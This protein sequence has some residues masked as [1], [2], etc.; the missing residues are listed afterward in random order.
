MALERIVAH[1]RAEV[2][3][4]KRAAD[5]DALREGLVPSDRSLAAALGR[6]R[7]GF[8]LEC[9]RAS[10]SAGMLRE[11]FDPEA[12]ARAY[13]PLADAV[14]VITD[15][16]FFG[17]SHAFLGR[18]RA[19]V[20]APVLCKDFV[21]DP[22]QVYEARHH[23]AD[24]IL[25]MLSVLDDDEYTACLRACE[26]AS[27]DALTEV[28]DEGEIDRALRLG[29]PIVGINNRNLKTLEV[30]LDTTRRLAPRVP[31]DRLVVCE[32][33]IGSR[34]DVRAL[35]PLANAFLI[36][37]ALMR[38]PDVSQAARELIHGP[39]K[40]CGLT[41]SED[42]RAAAAAGATHGG[43]VFAPESSRYVDPARAAELRQAPLQWVGVFV[44]EPAERVVGLAREL[45]LSAVQLHGEES[46]EYLAELRPLLPEGCEIW[47]ALRV[48][49]QPPT[50]PLPGVDRVVLDA[51]VDSARGGTGRSFDWTLLQ[52]VDL[53]QVV[54][55]GGIT[56]ETAA[57]AD[58]V[59]AWGLD[60]SSGVEDAPG[61]K[62]VARLQALFAAL[63]G[64]GRSKP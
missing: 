32:S 44:N 45:F 19:Q 20:D 31:P 37:S 7:T 27:L 53:S 14:S 61:I 28:H 46:P 62:S 43:L 55:A 13:A 59:G 60:L 18:V 10:P 36:G 35:R 12:I 33:G 25:L 21:V 23:G 49:D 22:F 29:A 2:A 38:A 42:A 26:A 48:R 6:A 51:H 41:R 17:G 64:Q 4:R 34:A 9:K 50:L 57:E 30:D 5:Q 15:E 24:A 16:R 47:R 58:R 1:K 52:D 40:I 63:R 39:V 3:E 11:D 54:L 56:P 8:V